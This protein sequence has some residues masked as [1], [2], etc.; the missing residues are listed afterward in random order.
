MNLHGMV[1]GAIGAVN[2]F[3]P[4]TIRISIGSTT[5]ASGKR[6]PLYATPGQITA[7]IDGPLL[8]VFGVIAGAPMVGQTLSGAGVV[9][10]TAIVADN[11]NGTYMV[12]PAQTVASETMDTAYTLAGQVQPVSTG[13]IRMLEGLNIQGVTTKIYM[14]GRINGLVRPDRKGGDLLTIQSGVW[15]GT[16]LVS[17][18]LEQFPD[19]CC[20]ALTRQNA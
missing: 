12:I 15:A 13:D 10:G 4:V 5:Q 18:I 9:P 14:S 11:G 16:Y 17:A 1:A 7:K 19:W 2:P 8:T 20:A 3:V 6:D